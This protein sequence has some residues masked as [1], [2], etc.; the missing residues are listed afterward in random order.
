MTLA[1]FSTL[2]RVALPR[3]HG[4]CC[5]AAAAFVASLHVAEQRSRLESGAM[6]SIAD[7][8]AKSEP[9]N[10][11][12]S[13]ERIGVLGFS[14]GG[15]VAVEM[16]RRDLRV[17][18]VVNLDGPVFGEAERLGVDRAY[19]AILADE[20]FAVAADPASVPDLALRFD[21]ELTRKVIDLQLRQSH[22]PDKWAFVIPGAAH[23]DFCDRLLYPPFYSFDAYPRHLDRASVWHSIYYYIVTFFVHQLCG[24]RQPLLADDLPLLGPRLLVMTDLPPLPK[25]SGAH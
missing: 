23:L 8:L 17:Q 15:A 9:W 16:A 24:G 25:H 21:A 7:G 12:V 2:A 22:R 3:L 14:F 20:L 4:Q 19:I 11:H 18:A 5:T 1:G 6:S 13:L 10:K